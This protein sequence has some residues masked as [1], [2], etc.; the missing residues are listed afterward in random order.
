MGFCKDGVTKWYF[1]K[2]ADGED[3]VY[4]HRSIVDQSKPA[5]FDIL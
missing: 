2:N 5:N 3:S 1:F 4:Y